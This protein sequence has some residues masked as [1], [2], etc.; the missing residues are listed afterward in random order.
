MDS[1]DEY[2]VQQFSDE[3]GIDSSDD[4]ELVLKEFYKQTDL[5]QKRSLKDFQAEMEKE[6]EFRVAT[7]LEKEKIQDPTKSS[8]VMLTWK[9]SQEITTLIQI[10]KKMLKEVIQ[11]FKN[12]LIWNFMIP[13]WIS[14]MK[15]MYKPN[16]TCTEKSTKIKP[17]SSFYLIVMQY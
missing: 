4:D 7:Y 2:I 16:E 11:Q 10:L 3:G 9:T 13:K 14:K 5:K 6:L 1:D 17:R 8:L 12:N 15:P